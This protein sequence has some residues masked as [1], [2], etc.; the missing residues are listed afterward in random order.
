MEEL[1]R[2]LCRHERRAIG[3]QFMGS[4]CVRRAERRA[5][6]RGGHRVP[7]RHNFDAS[8]TLNDERRRARR[9]RHR[10]H[11][12]RHRRPRVGSRADQPARV[13]AAAR[14]GAAACR[15][16]YRRARPD[17]RRLHSLTTSALH[18][19]P[20]NANLFVA[21]RDGF[22]ADLDGVAIETVEARPR[23]TWRDLDAPRAM[24]ANLLDSLDLPAG[25]PIAVQAEKSVES[26]IST[27]RCCAPATSTCRSTPPT[28][29]TRSPTSS[30]TPSRRCSSARPR[31]S[32]G[33][34]SSPSRPAPRSSSPSATT[35]AAACSSAPPTSATRTRRRVD[36]PA[37]SPRS[38]TPAAPPGAA[39]ARC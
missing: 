32:P 33:P 22:P 9:H 26:L 39:R 8:R 31:T 7:D 24:L 13:P 38:S 6:H 11:R 36:R 19:R 21:L 37:I 27:S 17:R 23:Y 29:A 4:I 3:A 10:G 5:P 16:V 12:C 18:D 1:Q 20:A 2:G 35:A 25:E 30:A 14:S 28:R 34:R 15:A